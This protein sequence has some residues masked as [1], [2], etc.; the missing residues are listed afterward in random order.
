MKMHQ[1]VKTSL[2][3][4]ADQVDPAVRRT[5]YAISDEMDDWRTEMLKEVQSVRKLLIGLTG[6]VVT[7]LVLGIAQVLLSL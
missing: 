5:L 4:D 1:I 2:N 3:G 7:G 6:T